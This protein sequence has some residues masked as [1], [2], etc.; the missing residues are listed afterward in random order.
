MRIGSNI[1]D[2]QVVSTTRLGVPSAAANKARQISPD[3]GDGGLEDKVSINVLTT[4]ALATPEI[5]QDQVD[6]LERM[7]SGGEYRLDPGQIASAM[8][9]Y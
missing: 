1:P 5:R 9:N 4:Q 7:V 3:E 8:L 6:N 2:L